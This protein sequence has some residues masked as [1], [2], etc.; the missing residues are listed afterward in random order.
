MAKNFKALLDKMSPAARDRAEAKARQMTA[1]MAL[2][3]LRAARELTQT[4]LAEEM[5]VE[6]S[7]VSKLE[8]RT[9]MYVGT[10]RRVVQAMGGELEIRAVFPEGTVRINQFG[11]L[12]EE[13]RPR[14]RAAGGGR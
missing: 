3:E 7:A 2:D 14:R 12:G 9:D 8:R 11:R 1:D 4:Q 10:L 5:G 6:Q 13:E